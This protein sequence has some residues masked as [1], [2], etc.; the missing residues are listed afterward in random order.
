MCAQLPYHTSWQELKDLIRPAGNII[1]ADVLYLPNGRPKGQGTVLFESSADAQRAIGRPSSFS[2]LNF[3]LFVLPLTF[4][5][6]M[7]NGYEFQ[8]RKLT[9]HEDKYAP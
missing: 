4:G 7:F 5:I 6:E 2:V 8:G 9:V 3:F 1:R